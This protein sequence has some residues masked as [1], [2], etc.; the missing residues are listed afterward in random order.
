MAVIDKEK[1][2]AFRKVLPASFKSFPKPDGTGKYTEKELQAAGLKTSDSCVVPM[3]SEADA[4]DLTALVAGITR[5]HAEYTALAKL[6]AGSTYKTKDGTIVPVRTNLL[7]EGTKAVSA[8]RYLLDCMVTGLR[9][10][11]QGVMGSEMRAAAIKKYGG[12]NP[13]V[14]DE[15]D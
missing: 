6:A 9:L 14:S 12:S 4:A 13:T 2:G 1:I 8:S 7:G 15:S 10:A 11:P 5:L 3:L